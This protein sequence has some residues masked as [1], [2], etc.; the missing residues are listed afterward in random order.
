VK[1]ELEGFRHS[2]RAARDLGIA[3]NTHGQY[4]E[5]IRRVQQEQFPRNT[6]GVGG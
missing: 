5:S 4:N 6:P 1:S 3:E 2:L